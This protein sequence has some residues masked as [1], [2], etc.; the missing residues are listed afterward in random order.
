MLR[1]ETELVR[2]EQSVFESEQNVAVQRRIVQRLVK[3]RLS[4]AIAEHEL[5]RMEEAL[6]IRR[7]HLERLQNSR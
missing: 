1:A 2:A 5:R 6:R 7:E 3:Q 4:I